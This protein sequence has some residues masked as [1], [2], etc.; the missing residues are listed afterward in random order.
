MPDHT[1]AE[2]RWSE[3]LIAAAGLTSSPA[4]IPLV[5]S[6]VDV[7]ARIAAGATAVGLWQTDISGPVLIP[8][9]LSYYICAWAC[10]TLVVAPTGEPPVRRWVQPVPRG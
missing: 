2:I 10:V 7:E 9:H 8:D 5:D 6:I 4:D 1:M 3:Q